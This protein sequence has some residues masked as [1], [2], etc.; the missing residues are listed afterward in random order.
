MDHVNSHDP[1]PHDM[2]PAIVLDAFVCLFSLLAELVTLVNS[3]SSPLA[4]VTRLSSCFVRL[5]ERNNDP[6]D[7]HITVVCLFVCFC[8]FAFLSLCGCRL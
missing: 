7:S 5:C 8:L 3:S 2:T 1:P 4:L 6:K